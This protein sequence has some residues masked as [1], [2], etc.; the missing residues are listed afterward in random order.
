MNA[1]QEK[2]QGALGYKNNKIKLDNF[3][4]SL[5]K[6][7]YKLTAMSSSESVPIIDIARELKFRGEFE[8]YEKIM[9]SM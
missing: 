2:V 5:R 7:T 6:K 4:F 8:P 1:Q 9:E 3:N